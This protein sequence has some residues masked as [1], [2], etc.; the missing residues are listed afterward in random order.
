[1]H[2]AIFKSAMRNKEN[3][4]ETKKPA[5]DTII[6]TKIAASAP[7]KFQS[8][9]PVTPN[10]LKKRH[11]VR[12]H[13]KEPEPFVFKAKP[14]PGFKQ[15]L[16]NGK[17]IT[18]PQQKLPVKSR[19]NPDL[20]D[21]TKKL[22]KCQLGQ[23]IT[24]AVNKEN[25]V[26]D[27][28][29][30]ALPALKPIAKIRPSRLEVRSEA[31]PLRRSKSVPIRPPLRV[32]VPTT[33]NVLKRIPRRTT[34]RLPDPTSSNF[35]KAKPAEV[36]QRQPF[37]PTLNHAAPSSQHPKP[38]HLNLESR[39]KD[40]KTFD[41][42]TT[43]ALHRKNQL[44]EDAKKLAQDQAYAAARRRTNFKANPNPFK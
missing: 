17:Q 31:P 29:K 25:I 43:D 11:R 13:H 41:H 8:T 33:P 42:K 35:F 5:V 16:N 3:L 15:P 23:P 21:V 24:K 14:A 26:Q 12:T 20:K 1:M 7:R 19:S 28:K 6:P 38:F 32:T 34:T 10:V 18:L 27:V 30:K 37:R 40:R 9:I 2:K 36:L 4:P 44:M 39:L 22:E